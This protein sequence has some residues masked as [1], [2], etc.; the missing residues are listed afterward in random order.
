MDA[1]ITSA[2]P[3]TKKEITALTAA[4]NGHIAAGE[5]INLKTAV[6]PSLLGGLTVQIGDKFLDLSASAKIAQLQRAL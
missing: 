6:D 3:L 5:K 2:D 4:L 1:V